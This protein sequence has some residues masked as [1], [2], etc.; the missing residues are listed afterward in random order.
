[1][2]LINLVGQRFGRWVVVAEDGRASDGKAAW[3]CICECGKRR[4]V[5]GGSLRRGLSKSCGCLNLEHLKERAIHGLAETPTYSIWLGIRQRCM[6]PKS[7]SWIKYGGRGITLC[8]RWMDYLNFLKDMGP[9]PHGM[10]IERVDNGGNYDP[11][12]CVWATSKTQ[13][14]NKRNTRKIPLNGRFVTL[15]AYMDATGMSYAAAYRRATGV[16]PLDSTWRLREACGF[17]GLPVVHHPA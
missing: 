6:N 3:L 12:N 14:Y 4:T 7:R 1:M 8:E 11:N 5:S 13:S 15:D 10:S 2:K 17:K 9:R 16:T